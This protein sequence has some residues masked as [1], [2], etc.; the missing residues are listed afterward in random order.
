[1]ETSQKFVIE[2]GSRFG[3][4]LAVSDMVAAMNEVFWLFVTVSE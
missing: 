4:F 1:L 2:L 3:T